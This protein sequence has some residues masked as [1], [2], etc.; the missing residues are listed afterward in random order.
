MLPFGLG[1]AVAHVLY[2]YVGQNI[3]QL[4]FSLFIATALSITALPILG[5]ML[6]EFNL[7][8]TRLV[9]LR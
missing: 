2:P 7:N 4:G 1:L 5:R 9:L 8:R 6:V 3:N